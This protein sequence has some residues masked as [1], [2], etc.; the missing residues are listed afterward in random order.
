MGVG[1]PF[2]EGLQR[3][4]FA[5]AKAQGKVADAAVNRVGPEGEGDTQF[6]RIARGSEEFY[7]LPPKAAISASISS[8]ST[9]SSV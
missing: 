3:K 7:F 6:F 4:L 2:G 8:S 5:A 1:D 9:T